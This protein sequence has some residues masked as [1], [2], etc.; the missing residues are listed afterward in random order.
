LPFAQAQEFHLPAPGVMVY[1]S[2]PIDPPIL[3]GIKVNPNNPFKFEF[4][5]DQGDDYDRH[6]ERSEGSQKEQLKEE[7][8]KLIKYFLASLTVPEKDLWVNLSPYEKDRIIPQAFGMT[9]MGRDLL[10]EDYMLKQIT[11]S[12]IYPEDEIGKKFWTRIYAEAVKCYGTT[13]IPVNTFNKV[14]IVPDKAIVYENPKAGT[15]Y[16]V[17]SKLKVMLEQDYLSLS[18][19]LNLNG[20]GHFKSSD[21]V[22]SATNALGS[23][24]VR[25]IVLPELTKEVN[26]NKNFAQ[27]R[28]VYNSLILATWYK[29]KIKDSILEQVYANKNKVREVGYSFSVIAR[30]EATK[31]SLTP[32]DVE[33]IYQRY[34]KAF[35]KGVYN[36]IKEDIDPATQEIIPRKYFSGGVTLDLEDAA[37][38]GTTHL[39]T[40]FQET[41]QLPD[42]AVIDND[43]AMII[44]S[45]FDQVKAKSKTQV[46]RFESFEDLLQFW[47]DQKGVFQKGWWLSFDMDQ[48]SHLGSNQLNKKLKVLTQLI[49][50]H[51]A[52]KGVRFFSTQKTNASDQMEEGFVY[53]PSNISKQ[54]LASVLRE[55]Q[56]DFKSQTK[57]NVS[58]AVIKAEDVMRSTTQIEYKIRPSMRLSAMTMVL[59]TLLSD[60]K[61][62]GEEYG[63][64]TLFYD[65]MDEVIQ[66]MWKHVINDFDNRA[67]IA[68]RSLNEYPVPQDVIDFFTQRGF[69]SS[70]DGTLIKIFK[71]GR[72]VRVKFVE[73]IDGS[74]TTRGQYRNYSGYLDG[75]DGLLLSF[76][77]YKTI[78]W[79]IR[80][81]LS[82]IPLL[83]SLSSRYS[84]LKTIRHE[85]AHMR[86]QLFFERNRPFDQGRLE[87]PVLLHEVFAGKFAAGNQS[88]KIFNNVSS[89]RRDILKGK[90]LQEYRKNNPKLAEEFAKKDDLLARLGNNEHVMPVEGSNWILAALG[91]GRL[92][93]MSTGN[94]EIDSFEFLYNVRQTVKKIINNKSSKNSTNSAMNSEIEDGLT[95]MVGDVETR[96]MSLRHFLKITSLSVMGGALLTSPKTSLAKGTMQLLAQHPERNVVLRGHIHNDG[97]QSSSSEPGRSLLE[98]IK[99]SI[100]NDY[101]TDSDLDKQLYRSYIDDLLKQKGDIIKSMK[102]DL[103]GIKEDVEGPNQVKTIAVEYSPSEMGYVYKEYKS[104]ILAMKKSMDNKEITHEKINDIFLY[105]LGPVFYLLFQKDFDETLAKDDNGFF[106]NHGLEIKGVDE[107]SAKIRMVKVVYSTSDKINELEN[108]VTDEELRNKIL[109]DNIQV[110]MFDFSVN[111]PLEEENLY[112]LA[113]NNV[114]LRKWVTDVLKLIQQLREELNERSRYMA[115]EVTHIQGNVLI[116]AGQMHFEMLKDELSKDK[117]NHL[118]AKPKD[119]LKRRVKEIIDKNFSK[120]FTTNQLVG[121]FNSVPLKM[122]AAMNANNK[123]REEFDLSI[124]RANFNKAEALLLRMK[125]Q[126]ALV[127]LLT[128]LRDVIE[129]TRSRFENDALS[130]N[131][132]L[133]DKKRLYYWL[134]LRQ[135]FFEPLVNAAGL[136]IDH[137]I[138]SLSSNTLSSIATTHGEDVQLLTWLE[139]YYAEGNLSDIEMAYLFA[140][141]IAHVKNGSVSALS[142]EEERENE[143]NDSVEA[144]KIMQ[145]A[146]YQLKD[147]KNK[148]VAFIRNTQ[149]LKNKAIAEGGLTVTPEMDSYIQQTHPYE[150]I[151]DAVDKKISDFEGIENSTSPDLSLVKGNLAMEAASD[152][153]NNQSETEKLI[154]SPDYKALENLSEGLDEQKKM[155]FDQ[156]VRGYPKLIKAVLTYGLRLKNYKILIKEKLNPSEKETVEHSLLLA[157][158][159]L[160]L[161]FRVNYSKPDLKWQ[162]AIIHGFTESLGD[163]ATQERINDEWDNLNAIN[164]ES[165]LVNESDNAA[166]NAHLPRNGGI[167][168]TPA[169]MNFQIQNAGA[170][171]KF[172]LDSA[173]LQELQN[174]SGFVPIITNIK[175]MTDLRGF[176]GIKEIVRNTDSVG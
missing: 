43:R 36:Y 133:I 116:I 140:H 66:S 62:S 84:I 20:P 123:L 108:I 124:E 153:S 104:A 154:L 99:D 101:S 148:V 29:K 88:K 7:A 68:T 37:M 164:V 46:Q 65:P 147:I 74:K 63:N 173:Q 3:K 21:Q 22:R 119:D 49:L 134:N 8:T 112:K 17:E 71:N 72:V 15:A 158:E 166:M 53:I 58:M 142:A 105:W 129:Q 39:Q 90:N 47:K 10:A 87:I 160:I 52:Y 143:I 70:S 152:E 122:N 95:G 172:H 81:G 55:L 73:W 83:Q 118:T 34:L 50:K 23:Q 60:A 117:Q 141:E 98:E 175:P 131:M 59:E 64:K 93:R 12:L 170:G 103:E 32:N 44:E 38:N 42:S 114:D 56:E 78:G 92:Q 11:A 157:R 174:A 24:I 115:E 102:E 151:A 69:K 121:L 48:A 18:N 146:G 128:D 136:N 25:E 110:I 5:L 139:D 111:H 79:K 135:K 94:E 85:Y 89:L 75:E 106:K 91:L 96:G 150:E 161:R 109:S 2:P 45:T 176:L 28:Q 100:T 26:E 171:I 165:T 16:V 57:Q 41:N 125:E 163:S 51:I 54:A 76:G 4:I 35:K 132:S 130:L 127:K 67:M 167:D 169:N 80:E 6:P 40:A 1:L 33:L 86:L 149:K 145:K 159:L 155:V 138:F 61:H 77:V 27:L 162:P 126:G 30:S 31:Q 113:G 144:I 107:Y 19:H 97:I 168:F 9:V 137:V 13:N 156:F 14:W 82:K 120:R